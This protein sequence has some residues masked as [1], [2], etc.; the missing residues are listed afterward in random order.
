MSG[1]SQASSVT[2]APTSDLPVDEPI[3]DTD[4]PIEE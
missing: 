2:K 3:S 1:Q 4:E